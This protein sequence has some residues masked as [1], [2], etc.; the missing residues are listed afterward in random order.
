[1]SSDSSSETSEFPHAWVEAFNGDVP[2]GAIEGGFNDKKDKLYVAR[3]FFKGIL[4]PGSLC[5]KDGCVYVCLEGNVGE[6]TAYEVL[7]ETLVIWKK[8]SAGRY[9]IPQ[10]SLVGWHTDESPLVCGRVKIKHSLVLG[11][12]HY[13]NQTFYAVYQGSVMAFKKFEILLFDV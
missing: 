6:L 9:E 12:Y 7:C 1:M 5:P 11:M 4:C 2:D 10:Q 13:V 3:G 8:T